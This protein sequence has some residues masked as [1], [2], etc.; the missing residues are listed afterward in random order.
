MLFTARSKTDFLPAVTHVDGSSRIQ[1]VSDASDDRFARLLRSFASLTD[2]P[3]LVNTSFN[4]AGNPIVCTPQN[5]FQCFLQTEMDVLVLGNCVILKK[6][7]GYCRKP[8][9]FSEK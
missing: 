2:I 3:V 5:A 1:T 6:E 7:I 9:G 8:F 4:T